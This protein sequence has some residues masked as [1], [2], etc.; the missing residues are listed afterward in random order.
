MPLPAPV[1]PLTLEMAEAGLTAAERHA[2]EME[3]M[4]LIAQRQRQEMLAEHADLLNRNAALQKKLGSRRKSSVG[5]HSNLGSIATAR[6]SS[7]AGSSS[8]TNVLVSSSGGSSSSVAATEGSKPSPFD[9]EI[10]AEVYDWVCEITKLSDVA[11][12][13]WRVCYS[14]RFFAS[15]TEEDQRLVMGMESVSIPRKARR[16]SRE[17][18]RVSSDE[19]EGT[20]EGDGGWDGAVVAVLGLFDKG[21]TFVLNRLTD[22]N[23]PSGKKVSTKGLSFKHVDVEGTKFVVLDSEGSYAP[24]KVENELS[25]V[26]KELSERFIQ[27]VCSGLQPP[28]LVPTRRRP[29]ILPTCIAD[30]LRTGNL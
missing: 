5:G 16:N 25:V 17:G 2:Q 22:S 23:L 15:M 19:E 13:G 4:F 3:A 21:K 24:V 20:V 10:D 30:V 27:D 8:H 6:E 1:R 18:P 28:N 14:E 12:P 29:S 26:E 11:V 7:S 9:A